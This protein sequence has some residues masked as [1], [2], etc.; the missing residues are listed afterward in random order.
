MFASFAQIQPIWTSLSS[1]NAT[2]NSEITIYAADSL[3]SE[4][5]I[6]FKDYSSNDNGNMIP[7]SMLSG[8]VSPFKWRL[9]VFHCSGVTFT[10]CGN[11]MLTSQRWRTDKKTL[12]QTE[13][14]LNESSPIGAILGMLTILFCSDHIIRRSGDYWSARQWI[15]VLGCCLCRYTIAEKACT[16]PAKLPKH[17]KYTM[18]FPVQSTFTSHDLERLTAGWYFENDRTYTFIV[19]DLWVFPPQLTS[20]ATDLT[21]DSITLCMNNANDCKTVASN[22]TVLA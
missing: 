16:E 7:R 19:R 15:N 3:T 5:F 2:V 9:V 10:S 13:V 21:F 14:I 6:D 20:H 17:I 8:I 12:R 11:R 1:Q 18:C 22:S 4:A